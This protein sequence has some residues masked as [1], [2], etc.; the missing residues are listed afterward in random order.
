MKQKVA[1]SSMKIFDG[2]DLSFHKL[3]N[4]IV[5]QHPEIEKSFSKFNKETGFNNKFKKNN[6]LIRTVINYLNNF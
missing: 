4:S 5:K 1:I 2:E 3:F 6:K